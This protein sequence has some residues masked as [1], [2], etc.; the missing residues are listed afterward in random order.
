MRYNDICHD[1]IF[2]GS[3]MD[4]EDLISITKISDLKFRMSGFHFDEVIAFKTV[5]ARRACMWSSSGE[6]FGHGGHFG[7]AY[8][9]TYIVGG[10]Y[11]LGRAIRQYGCYF[12]FVR[13]IVIFKQ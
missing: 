11:E 9:T 1:A 4:I 10:V 7:A 2:F 8:P 5:L 12:I 13:N 3:D 6:L